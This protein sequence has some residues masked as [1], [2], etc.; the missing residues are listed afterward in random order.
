LVVLAGALLHR[1]GNLDEVSRHARSIPTTIWKTHLAKAA[2]PDAISIQLE[3]N[4]YDQL[5]RLRQRKQAD[6][7][8]ILSEDDYLSATLNHGGATVPAKI[9]LAAS[10]TPPLESN[11]WSFRIQTD[12]ASP[13]LGMT[14]FSLHQSRAGDYL[15]SWIEHQALKREGVRS[16]RYAFA[17]VTLNGVDLGLCVLE[18]HLEHRLPHAVDRPGSLIVQLDESYR[19]EEVVSRAGENAPSSAAPTEAPTT[20][21]PTGDPGVTNDYLKAFS[22]LDRFRS[23]Q[24]KTSEVFD[25]N[26]LAAWFAITDLTGTLREWAWHDLQFCYDP[27]TSRLAPIGMEGCGWRPTER[28]SCVPEVKRNGRLS[29]QSLAGG[30]YRHFFEDPAFLKAYLAKLE[31]VSQPVYV[32]KLFTDI[33]LE[34]QR[35]LAI[36]Y[37]ESPQFDYSTEVLNRNQQYI[38]TV[39]HPVRGL[40]AYLQQPLADR[41]NLQLGNPHYLPTV[42]LDAVCGE[43]TLQPAQQNLMLPGKSESS[44]ISYQPLAFALP[45]GMAWKDE[46]LLQLRV[47]YQVLGTS[48]V[49]TA[50]VTHWPYMTAAQLDMDPTRKPPNVGEFDFLVVDDQQRQISIKPGE[51]TIASDLV[52]PPGYHFRCEGGV[53]LNLTAD[54]IVISY[55]PWELSGTQD[56]PV[57]IRS[58]DSKGEAVAIMNA[59][60]RSSLEHVVFQNLGEPRRPGWALT[61]AVTFYES[62]VEFHHCRFQDNR[63]E[64]SLNT[65]RTSFLISDCHFSHTQGDAFDA[66]FCDGKVTSSTFTNIGNDGID[67]SGSHAEIERVRCEQL[68]D[69]GLSIGEKST[70]VV[71]DVDV[72]GARIGFAVKDLSSFHGQQITLSQCQYGVVTLRKKPEYGPASGDVRALQMQSVQVPYLLEVGT[73][74]YMDGTL[75]QPNAEN[76]KEELYDI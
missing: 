75:I 28:L 45:E 57:V 74:L 65:V 76:L 40:I 42:V 32:E 9:R 49:Q 67:I 7:V 6:D 13:V 14:H 46:M 50:T 51:W 63:S 11:P 4:N 36:I 39:L 64:D 2:T 18:E 72:R 27:V 68:G 55:S 25:V 5:V 71:R 60:E 22:L 10:P 3:A 30:Y 66:D 48:S 1:S 38:R 20:A 23:G 33:D 43:W 62:P 53:T 24:S 16:P 35:N 69:K 58:L 17:R 54:A 21:D 12:P 56:A 34:L 44:I 15:D 73:E 29:P 31:E 52:I 8:V 59:G 70:A 41:L 26:R 61:G 19:S 47:R 37:S